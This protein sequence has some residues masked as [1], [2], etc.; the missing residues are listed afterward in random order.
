[1]KNKKIVIAGGTGFIG[2]A[3]AAYFG[4]DNHIVII[5]RQSVNAHNNG[6]TK[7]LLQP[8]QGY[9]ITYRRWDGVH[10][11]KHWTSELE[12]ADIL[13]NLAGK[14]VNC[15]YTK[16]NKKEIFDSRV[17]ATKALGEAVRNCTVPPRLW[18]NA[19]SA[20]I[21]RHATD[22]PQDEYNG[23]FHD[24]F[25]VQVCKLWEKT[26]AEQR[27]PFTRKI[28]LRMAITLG[29]G[30]VMVPYCNL[31]KWGLGGRQGNG[32]Q[33]YSW[34]HIDDVCR[35]VAWMQEHKEMEGV[36]NCA[37]PFPVTND[38]FMK[39]LRTVTG[40]AIG[41]PAYEWMLSIGVLLIGTEKELLL[42]SRWVLPIKIL[43]TGFTFKYPKLADALFEIIQKTDR[44]KY[45]LFS[46]IRKTGKTFPSTQKF[47]S[48]RL[49]P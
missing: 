12:G 29:Q 15:R 8:A 44:K 40:H 1:M 16:K 38:F 32:R 46:R 6:Y 2:Q 30:G 43:E 5:S 13:I 14:S 26:F 36:Y 23:E 4:K 22:H 11:E 19:A 35:M 31:L 48:C 7:Q 47:E 33:M 28:T 49:N 37:S 10:P 27:T 18:I 25:S 39:T 42:K 17:N 9:D 21:Y 20:T 34:V 24:D 41:L 45:H 3:M